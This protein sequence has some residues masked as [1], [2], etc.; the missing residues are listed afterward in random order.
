[1]APGARNRQKGNKRAPAGAQ[2]GPKDA[3]E[4]PKGPPRG[5]FSSPDGG[6]VRRTPKA[7]PTKCPTA[8]VQGLG[9]VIV[10]M[11]EGLSNVAK[12]LPRGVPRRASRGVACPKPPLHA[13]MRLLWNRLSVGA[14]TLQNDFSRAEGARP[15]PRLL[16]VDSEGS[17]RAPRARS[18]VG[19]RANREAAPD[20][21]AR[22]DWPRGV[23]AGARAL[24]GQINRARQ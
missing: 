22:C 2:C 6:L 10:Q 11:G 4:R 16:G 9:A 24:V 17:S 5:R 20:A 21:A 12:S 15:A 1:M 7:C 13:R 8:S 19:A 18:G 14:R 3:Q 23:A